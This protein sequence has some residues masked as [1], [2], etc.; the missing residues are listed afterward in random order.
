LAAADIAE[1]GQ[2]LPVNRFLIFKNGSDVEGHQLLFPSVHDVGYRLAF[3]VVCNAE[4]VKWVAYR[5]LL[6]TQAIIC[7]NLISTG[8]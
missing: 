8:S 6:L 4:E 7:F 3:D 1:P 2:Y 5:F